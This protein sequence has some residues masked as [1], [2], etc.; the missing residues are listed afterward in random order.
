MKRS[1][2]S[3][4]PLDVSPR[5]QNVQKWPCWHGSKIMYNLCC[6]WEWFSS[7]VCLSWIYFYIISRPFCPCSFS[8]SQIAFLPTKINHNNHVDKLNYIPLI[9]STEKIV[10]CGYHVTTWY[11]TWLLIGLFLV[12]CPGKKKTYLRLPGHAHSLPLHCKHKER[13]WY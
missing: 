1:I 13:I 5:A 6:V 12:L 3:V 7:A 9:L 11:M 10:F 8:L 4:V 2:P